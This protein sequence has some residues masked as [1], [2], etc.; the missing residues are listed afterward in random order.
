MFFEVGLRNMVQKQGVVIEHYRHFFIVILG[1][2]ILSFV[3]IILALLNIFSQK[4]YQ[5]ENANIEKISLDNLEN[6]PESLILKDSPTSNSRNYRC[7]FYDCFN[8]Y[9][10]GRKGLDQISVYV[11][12]MR[13]FI[14]ENGQQLSPQLTKEFYAILKTIV[15]SKYYTPNPKEACILVP[16]IDTLNQ[17]RLRLKEISQALGLLS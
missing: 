1:V 5:L 14:D 16:S 8:V 7:S 4:L 2:I 12:P 13:K 9:R 17:N 15:N 3:I 6:I 11:Y 10:C